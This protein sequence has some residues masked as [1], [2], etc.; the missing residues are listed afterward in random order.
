MRPAAPP[1]FGRSRMWRPCY[2]ISPD[3]KFPRG[4]RR[5]TFVCG[6]TSKPAQ[7]LTFC[8]KPRP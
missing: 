2:R 1:I 7:H 3:A 6:R 8:D 5:T 4:N